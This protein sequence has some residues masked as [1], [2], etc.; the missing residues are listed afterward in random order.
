MTISQPAL[1]A[2]DLLAWSDMTARRWRAL[3]EGAP[4]LLAV[5]CDIRGASTVADLLL[6]IAAAELRY[7]QQLSGQSPTEYK[8]LS[9]ATASDLFSTHERAMTLFR[10][11][12]DQEDYSWSEEFTVITRSAGKLRATRQDVFLHALLHGIRH[13]AQ[14]ATLARHHGH[15]PDWHM[16]FLFLHAEQ[17]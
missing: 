15:A 17:I 3:V 16:D 11:L 5:P 7:A 1:T 9:S 14:L 12:L 13:Y 2:E 10:A 8:D 4:E 6:H